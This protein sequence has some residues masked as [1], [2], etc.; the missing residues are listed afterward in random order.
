VENSQL[1][2]CSFASVVP[3][4]MLRTKSEYHQFD[5]LLHHEQN[6]LAISIHS[7][8]SELTDAQT[9]CGTAL[10]EVAY[11]GDLDLV[12]LLLDNGADVKS[13]DGWA[14]QT[15]AAEG[16]EKIV[17]ELLKR[18]ADVNA[19]TANNNFPA[20]TALQ[21]AAEAGKLDIVKLLLKQNNVNPSLGPGLHTSPLIA[22]TE[23]GEDKIVELL[24]EAHANVNVFG[25]FDGSTPLIKAALYLPKE[26]VELILKAGAY[27]N[28]S[29]NEGD[30]ALMAAA[31]RGDR[32]CVEYL[33]GE[34]ADIMQSNK[35]G[36]NAI[37]T[38]VENGSQECLLPLVKHA[39]AILSAIR[40][41]MESGNSIV[42]DVIR[43][44][45]F[46]KQ[47]GDGCRGSDA[48]FIA[49]DDV[50]LLA[51]SGRGSE[52]GTNG[53]DQ[54]MQT[55]EIDQP[56]SMGLHSRFDQP[57]KLEGTIE[58]NRI[59]TPPPTTFAELGVDNWLQ[60]PSW[61]FT[62]DQP[63]Q[64]WTPQTDTPLT[65]QTRIKRK[66]PPATSYSGQPPL[67]SSTARSDYTGSP[68]QQE[69]PTLPPK[70][71]IAPSLPPRTSLAQ[72]ASSYN[73][74]PNTPQYQTWS[75]DQNAYIN[76]NQAT[77]PPQK[78]PQFQSPPPEGQPAPLRPYAPYNPQPYPAE[79][80]PIS[81]PPWS[82]G[83]PPQNQSP[84]QG[85]GYSV[86]N[87]YDG[88]EYGGWVGGSGNR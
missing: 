21:A 9:R 88:D 19:C 46:V 2:K 7:S 86:G 17:E 76:S 50:V 75:P 58:H 84:G 45:K 73:P 48:S 82:S 16:H 57:S 80:Y 25:G 13:T 3:T 67:D 43:S 44:V 56:S 74:N 20:G 37:Q 40:N 23:R 8:R 30:T 72:S 70:E 53:D 34:G 78:R 60:E 11:N 38:A 55:I 42:A 15:A 65:P 59:D 77:S 83:S 27:I 10:T 6:A 18:G 63:T 54:L 69:A 22:A 39:S 4:R 1:L 5:H 66:A 36:L 85:T 61:N 79:Q 52:G 64:Q 87:P 14:L 26:S 33:L 31:Y 41:A 51:S 28:T 47:E 62:T 12:K 29:D 81:T 49:N 68:Y 71:Q 24:I 35:A 32:D